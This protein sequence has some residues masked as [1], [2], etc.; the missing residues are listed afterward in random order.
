MKYLV[1]L[2]GLMIHGC[3]VHAQGGGVPELGF[4]TK[5]ATIANGGTVSDAIATGGRQLVAIMT[6]AAFTGTAMTFSVAPSLAGTYLP[7]KTT[8]AGTVYTQTVTTSSY[9]NID[10]QLTNGAPF[11]KVTSGSAE[12][13]DRSV[14]LVFKRFQ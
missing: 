6:P 1:L 2:F 14:T 9:Y 8:A 13:A 4:Y 7:L 10:P 11:I 5:T 3:S 12:G